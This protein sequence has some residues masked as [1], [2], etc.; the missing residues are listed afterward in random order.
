MRPLLAIA[1]ILLFLCEFMFLEKCY[2]NDMV[3]QFCL[4]LCV[5]MCVRQLH[6]TS[7]SLVLLS[8]YLYVAHFSGLHKALTSDDALHGNP[9]EVG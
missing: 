9:C 1:L 2:Y 3:Q 5:C 7:I 8:A 4:L 6:D